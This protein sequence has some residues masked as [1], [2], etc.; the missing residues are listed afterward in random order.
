MIKR[1]KHHKIPGLNMAS[2][3]DLIFT[4]LF[5][6]MIVTHM[7]QEDVKVNV[8]TP[9]GTEV[10]KVSK[11]TSAF[12]IYIGTDKNGVTRVQVNDKLCDPLEIQSLL[13]Q[14]RKTLSDDERESMTVSIKADKKTPM[15]IVNDIKQQLQ[16]AGAL[17]VNYSANEKSI[18]SSDEGK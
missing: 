17:N 12:R 9:S 11:R 13:S 10:S 4:V 6:F 7:K 2:M 15:G 14:Y 5:F 1:R 18:S 8:Q 16:R 3:P